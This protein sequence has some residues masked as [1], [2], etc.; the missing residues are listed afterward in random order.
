MDA[1]HISKL[2]GCPG[3]QAGAAQDREI[4][5]TYRQSVPLER[6]CQSSELLD[7][8]NTPI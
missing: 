3:F 7:Y 4:R 6:V 2:A 1:L 8:R 5:P